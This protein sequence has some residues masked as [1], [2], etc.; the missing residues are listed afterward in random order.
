MDICA[1]GGR[2]ASS[3]TE[4]MVQ[5]VD[6]R[7]HTFRSHLTDGVDGTVVR[8]IHRLGVYQE[9]RHAARHTPSTMPS[10]ARRMGTIATESF[11]TIS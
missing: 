3:L 2:Q 10:P 1:A 8:H 6:E 7:K 5:T 11:L 9:D 4:I